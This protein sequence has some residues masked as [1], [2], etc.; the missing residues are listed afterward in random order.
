MRMYRPIRLA[1]MFVLVCIVLSAP[2]S[3]QSGAVSPGSLRSYST[4]FSVGLE[5]DVSGD[6]NHDAT[7]ALEYRKTGT[8]TWQPALPLVRVDY[9]GSDTLAGSALFL[10]PD[11][12]YDL[13]IALTDPDGGSQTRQVTV[14]TR[15]GAHRTSNRRIFH[16]V[17]VIG[18]GDG[19]AAAPFGG[20]AA[21]EAVRCRAIRSC[22]MRALMEGASGS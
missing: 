17:P 8:S 9:N 11:T 2:A 1:W 10:A 22:C 13:K 6:D 14:R 5:W 3:A 21:A 16:V 12:S 4:I 19:S 7:A 15:P 20:I 18:G